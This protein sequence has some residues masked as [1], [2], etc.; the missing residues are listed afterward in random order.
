VW[1]EMDSGRSR[2]EPSLRT[3]DRSARAKSGTR[4]RN[5]VF[6]A[7]RLNWVGM[8]IAALLMLECWFREACSC[9]RKEMC[10]VISQDLGE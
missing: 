2:C 8:V 6:F 4:Y 3:Q 9:R 1:R 7:R 10:T 5:T